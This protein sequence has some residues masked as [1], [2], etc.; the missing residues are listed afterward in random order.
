[1]TWWAWHISRAGGTSRY[2]AYT[3]MPLYCDCFEKTHFTYGKLTALLPTAYCLA[4][5]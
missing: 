2:F 4:W 1:M 3:G 5:L